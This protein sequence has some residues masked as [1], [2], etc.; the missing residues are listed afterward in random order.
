[1]LKRKLSQV[2]LP[3]LDLFH[4]PSCQHLL[5]TNHCC[6]RVLPSEGAQAACW[7]CVLGMSVEWRRN[8]GLMACRNKL[9]SLLAGLSPWHLRKLLHLRKG[10]HLSKLPRPLFP[11]TRVC[12]RVCTCCVATKRLLTVVGERHRRKSGWTLKQ[13]RYDK[14]GKRAFN[15]SVS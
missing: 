5:V 15:S 3:P 12:T 8:A 2:W 13:E 6:M 1:V 4:P 14:S 10:L 9:G 11:C 7:S